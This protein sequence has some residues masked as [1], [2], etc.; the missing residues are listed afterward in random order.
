MSLGP[1]LTTRGCGFNRGRIFRIEREIRKK[2]KK[3]EKGKINE[4][5]TGETG[6]TLRDF[7]FLAVAFFLLAAE[8]LMINFGGGE[9]EA[10]LRRRAEG[11]SDSSSAFRFAGEGW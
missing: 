6:T 4:P 2:Y 9:G 10:T 8:G 5:R 11:A 7:D 3:R 1:S